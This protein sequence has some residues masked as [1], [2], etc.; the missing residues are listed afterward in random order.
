MNFSG[1]NDC[2]EREAGDT[3][4]VPNLRSY[5]GVRRELMGLKVSTLLLCLLTRGDLNLFSIF[6]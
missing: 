3:A 4:S 1:D 5:V 6:C 2:G